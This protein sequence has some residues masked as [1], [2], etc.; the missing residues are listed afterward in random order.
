[1]AAG[2]IRVDGGSEDLEERKTTITVRTQ[3]KSIMHKT[4]S[5]H[6]LDLLRFRRLAP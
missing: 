1:V 4:Q 3:L 5:R 2:R 6:Q